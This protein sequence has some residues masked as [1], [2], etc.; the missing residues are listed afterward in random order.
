LRIGAPTF[1]SRHYWAG[2]IAGLSFYPEVLTE[3]ELLEH[4]EGRKP[5]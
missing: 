2:R 3:E 5:F 1:G 4:M